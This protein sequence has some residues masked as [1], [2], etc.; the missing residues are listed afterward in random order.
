MGDPL[1]GITGDPQNDPNA[2]DASEPKYVT[3]DQLNAALTGYTSRIEKKLMGNLSTALKAEL[4]P[5]LEGL[6]P[7]DSDH[8]DDPQGDSQKPDS[9]E[10][11]EMK[12]LRSQLQKTEN[13]LKD[14]ESKWEADRKMA[15]EE[16]RKNIISQAVSGFRQQSILM[17]YVRDAVTWSGDGVGEPFV[18]DS[19]L[20]DW[21]NEWKKSD[22]AKPYIPA[23]PKD[24]PGH[25]GSTPGAS[26]PS[27]LLYRDELR[28]PEEKVKF[29]KEHGQDA[30]L[31][32]RNRPRE[33]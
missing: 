2:G 20:S 12:R 15:I 14:I 9:Q 17:P 32:L 31:A 18:G 33:K 21:I 5:I 23:S 28:T 1:N 24:G 27:K 19:P 13:R 3:A 26:P 4:A 22:D 16:K 25:D 29:I 30:F 8:D 7:H 6:K 10:T 11:P